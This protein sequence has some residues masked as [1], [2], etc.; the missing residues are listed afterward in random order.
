MHGL[1][2]SKLIHYS[3]ILLFDFIGDSFSVENDSKIQIL[4]EKNFTAAA[5]SI[6]NLLIEHHVEL[7]LTDSV[8]VIFKNDDN[9]FFVSHVLDTIPFAK[10]KLAGWD[11][12][13]NELFDLFDWQ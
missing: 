8:T 11:E 4:S 12:T 7:T 6:A 2:S 1:L 13:K 3:K 5:E 9:H 10:S